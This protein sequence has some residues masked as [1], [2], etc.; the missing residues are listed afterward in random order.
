MGMRIYGSMPPTVIG[1]L[2]ISSRMK[3]PSGIMFE[4]QTNHTF[5]SDQ[6]SGHIVRFEPPSQGFDTANSATLG[7]LNFQGRFDKVFT[8]QPVDFVNAFD[9]TS[10]SLYLS[11]PQSKAIVRYNRTNGVYITH[12]E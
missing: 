2:T 6:M 11:S 5:I 10:H 9:F 8:T 1:Q 7:S 12:F 3:Y 4:R